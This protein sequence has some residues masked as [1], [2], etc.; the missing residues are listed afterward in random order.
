LL[1]RV[2]DL[3]AGKS[4]TLKIV[5]PQTKGVLGELSALLP[6]SAG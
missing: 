6:M 4:V 1:G 3:P 5:N 2:Q